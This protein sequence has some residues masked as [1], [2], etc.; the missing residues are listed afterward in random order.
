[1]RFWWF[2]CI[3]TWLTW[4]FSCIQITHL[5][6]PGVRKVRSQRGQAYLGLLEIVSSGADTV[7]KLFMPALSTGFG[8][9]EQVRSMPTTISLSR[10]ISA[11]KDTASSAGFA[12]GNV[13]TKY[14]SSARL[15]VPESS[16]LLLSKS[17]TAGMEL[18]GDI[19]PPSS[20][21]AVSA[22]EAQDYAVSSELQDSIDWKLTVDSIRSAVMCKSSAM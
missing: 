1:L 21:T 4:S 11:R 22:V 16:I 8:G 9:L 15:P 12:T 5:R 20:S 14:V 18:A 17:G 10:Y 6:V 7:S 2:L 13:A 3:E 19:S